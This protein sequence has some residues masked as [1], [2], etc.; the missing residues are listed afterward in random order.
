[1]DS[2]TKRAIL[3]LGLQSTGSDNCSNEQDKPD[4]ETLIGFVEQSL[5]DVEFERVKTHFAT[6]QSCYAH[7]VEA[8]QLLTDPGLA[9]ILGQQQGPGEN[10]VNTGQQSLLARLRQWPFGV[11]GMAGGL[12]TALVVAIVVTNLPFLAQN[13]LRTNLASFSGSELNWLA[14]N[15][16][17]VK[18]FNPLFAQN[19]DHITNVNVG[20]NQGLSLVNLTAPVPLPEDLAACPVDIAPAACSVNQEQAQE[21][22]LWLTLTGFLCQDNNDTAIQQHLDRLPQLQNN[23]LIFLIDELN[24][25]T[26]MSLCGSAEVLFNTLID[27]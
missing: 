16:Q 27:R 24:T 10:N 21:F 12:A 9:T 20:I 17:V 25:S 6:C 5:T 19:P 2:D 15:D 8:R 14:S 23:G 26:Q 11:Y 4:D 18:S 22:G 7:Y 1:M 3:M 13:G